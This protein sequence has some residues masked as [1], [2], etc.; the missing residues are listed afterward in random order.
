[1]SGTG[2]GAEDIVLSKIDTSCLYGHTVVGG[3]DFSGLVTALICISDFIFII[4][5]LCKN[6][7]TTYTVVLLLIN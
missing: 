6:S 3:L 4:I 5:W 1:M 7:V 2:P